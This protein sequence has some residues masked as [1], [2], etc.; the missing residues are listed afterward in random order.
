MAD[1]LKEYLPFKIICV[2]NFIILAL[3]TNGLGI[4]R[5]ISFLDA[6]F[7]LAHPE[8]PLDQKSDSPDKDK[9]IADSHALQPA[10][11]DFFSLHPDFHHHTFLGDSAFDTIDTYGFLKDEFHFTK[12]LIPYNHRNESTLPKVGY[13]F[14]GYPTCPKEPSLAMKYHGITREKGRADRVK[15]GCPKMHFARGAYSSSMF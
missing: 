10:L 13:N 6:P 9:S 14:Y 5:H 2:K 4:V 11:S 7:Q 8:V 3:L 1:N 15:W 12:A